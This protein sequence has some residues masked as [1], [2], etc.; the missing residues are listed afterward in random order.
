MVDE[1]YDFNPELN[2]TLCTT[3]EPNLTCQDCRETSINEIY[4]AHF[5]SSCGKPEKCYLE[6]ETP[7]CMKLFMEWHR[8]RLSLEKEWMA[9]Y[10]DYKPNILMAINGTSSLSNGKK[11]IIQQL[12]GHCSGQGSKS[13]LPLRLP[14]DIHVMKQ[15][16][17]LT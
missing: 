6:H 1:P 16:H 8:V 7:L 14:S 9:K 4:T 10:N 3:V 2:E 15:K 13:Y 5:T 12:G 17:E 11:K